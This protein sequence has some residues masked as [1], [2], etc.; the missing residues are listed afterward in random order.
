MESTRHLLRLRVT[1]AAAVLLALSS[2]VVPGSVSGRP[3]PGVSPAPV[4]RLSRTPSAAIRDTSLQPLRL[5]QTPA[6]WHGGPMTASTGEA[7]TVFVSDSYPPDQVTP[8]AWADFFAHLVHGNELSLVQIYVAPLSEVQAI[9]GQ[10]ALACYGASR[11]VI[12]GETAGGNTAQDIA[13]HEY[14]HHVAFNRPATPWAAI[15]W[16]TKRWA[17]YTNVCAR[18][19][20]GT[21]FPGDEGANYKLNPGEAFA[22][23]YRV[24]N[25]TKDGT[26]V[27]WG[28][29]DMSFLPDATALGLVKRD[30]VDPWAASPPRTISGLFTPKGRTSSQFV[31]PTPLD[32][33]LRVS[34]AMPTGGMYDLKLLTPGGKTLAS[35][36]WSGQ[37]AKAL[38]FTI[39]GQRSV[40]LRVTR[41]GTPGRYAVKITTP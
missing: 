31:L 34:L 13:T 37:R 5:Q 9:C 14:G 16:G 38:S 26:S 24:L 20:Q 1:W 6:G 17:S 35:G 22:E 40:V 2:S 11:L 29:V 21:A 19:A 39:C 33:D 27:T 32:G 25:T 30:V 18:V 7:V 36:L 10:Y 3:G 23:A 12:P 41:V 28:L 4:V 15:D 8:Q